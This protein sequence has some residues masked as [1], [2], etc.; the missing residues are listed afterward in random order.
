MTTTRP[1]RRPP[2]VAGTRVTGTTNARFAARAR[3]ARWR[4]RRPLLIGL[5]VLVAVAGLGAFLYAGPALVVRTVSVSGV[6]AARTLQVRA[7]AD[8]P[9]RR[10]LAQV[11]TRLIAGRVDALPFVESVTVRRHWPSTLQIV[12]EPRAPAAVVPVAVGRYRVVD[13]SGVAFATNVAPI[14][15]L[16]VVKVAL[17][18]SDRP[19]LQAALEVL[20]A[21]P[22]PVRATVGSVTASSPDDVRLRVGRSTVVWGSVDRSQRKAQ[23]YAALR[24]TPATVYDL[25]SP[26]TPVLR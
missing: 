26:D 1:V 25:S 7:A 18:E 17:T 11:D 3:S 9:M 22:A 8:A 23:I 20:A 24:R 15:G 4:H 12:V 21:L 2:R 5:A 13:L 14:K 10:P 6:S 19:A 16:P